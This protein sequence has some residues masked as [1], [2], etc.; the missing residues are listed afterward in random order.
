MN[1]LNSHL[2]E[3]SDRRA[4]A[5]VRPSFG[6]LP[7][8]LLPGRHVK[9]SHCEV[10]QAIISALFDFLTAPVSG[11]VYLLPSPSSHSLHS[12]FR[13]TALSPTVLVPRTSLVTTVSHHSGKSLAE[14]EHGS[15]SQSACVSY[16]RRSLSSGLFI[17]LLFCRS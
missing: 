14:C 11:L 2:P 17:C 15:S 4:V 5:G 8:S 1:P 16:D 9:L 13:H 6:A 12:L 7:S 3:L 10:R